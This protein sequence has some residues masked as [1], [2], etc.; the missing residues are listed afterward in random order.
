MHIFAKILRQQSSRPSNCEERVLFDLM[1][2]DAT[3]ASLPALDWTARAFE[4]MQDMQGSRKQIAQVPSGH[5]LRALNSDHRTWSRIDMHRHI[6]THIDANN[7]EE[8]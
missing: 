4:L 7:L 8:P 2:L 1:L 3:F 5:H 6:N